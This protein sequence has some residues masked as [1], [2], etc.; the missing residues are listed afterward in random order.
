MLNAF[1]Y[2]SRMGAFD[3]SEVMM[4]TAAADQTVDH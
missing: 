1:P 4:A 3:D 2:F